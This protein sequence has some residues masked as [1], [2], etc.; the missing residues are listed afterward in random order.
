MLRFLATLLFGQGVGGVPLVTAERYWVERR[1]RW[2]A[3]VFGTRRM[4]EAKVATP[5]TFLEGVEL[6]GDESDARQLLLRIETHLGLPRG[7]IPI[8]VIADERLP[9]AAGHYDRE[10]NPI[11]RVRRSLVGDLLPLTSTL[12][13]EVMHD[14]LLGPGHLSGLEADH[15]PTTDL[16]MVFFGL[17]VF[18]ANGTV[19]SEST[20]T[21]NW[22]SWSIGRY[23]YLPSRA[24][25][26]ALALFAAWRNE[27]NP[28]W[29]KHLRL[30]AATTFRLGR[31][32]LRSQDDCLFHPLRDVPRCDTWSVEKVV[33]ELH[34]GGPVYRFA[35]LQRMI[36]SSQGENWPPSALAPLLRSRDEDIASAAASAAVRV[37]NIDDELTRELIGALYHRAMPVR[38]AAA[39]VL[40]QLS[41]KLMDAREELLRLVADPDSELAAAAATAIGSFGPADGSQAKPLLQAHRR[42]MVGGLHHLEQAAIVAL[43]K[44]HSDPRDALLKYYGQFDEEFVAWALESYG[45]YVVSG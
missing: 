30:D 38:I 4:I 6:Q 10:K 8:E 35:A 3:D 45:E 24:F 31:K 28:D 26:Y 41:M 2:L 43:S 29:A 9:G 23:G 34:S 18:A 21:G 14:M 32:H 39:T 1:M 37:P 44:I 11:I 13:H 15:E 27:V 40:G 12:V 17:G 7:K 36:E 25:G 20:R 42:A 16:A 33:Q 19:R 5:G 22:E